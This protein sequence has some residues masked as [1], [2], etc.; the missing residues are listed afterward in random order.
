MHR[1]SE[2]IEQLFPIRADD[3]DGV[4]AAVFQDRGIKR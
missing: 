1:L 3:D 4:A 2:N